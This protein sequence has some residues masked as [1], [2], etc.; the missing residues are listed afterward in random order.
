MAAK[1]TVA[2]VT[3][4]G[5]DGN[6]PRNTIDGDTAT[7]WSAH[8]DGQWIQWDLGSVQSLSQVRIAF[9]K[10]NSRINTFDIEVSDGATSTRVENEPLRDCCSFARNHAR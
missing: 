9:Y 3:A 8:G 4:S 6:G 5:D 7:R 2:G 10:G 1:L